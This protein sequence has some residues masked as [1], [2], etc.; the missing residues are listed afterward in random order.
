MPKLL[1][2]QSVENVLKKMQVSQK[3]RKSF[4]ITKY[5]KKLKFFLAK[6]VKA[7]LGLLNFFS[8]RYF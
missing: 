8:M 2:G 1:L 6:V 5:N 7:K 4:T 3:C